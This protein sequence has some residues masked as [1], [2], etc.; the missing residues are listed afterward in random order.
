MKKLQL[1]VALFLVAGTANIF[2]GKTVRNTVQQPTAR[3]Q[4][5]KTVTVAAVS[6]IKEN[7]PVN[8]KSEQAAAA[9]SFFAGRPAR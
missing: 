6:N 3:K 7:R 1:F 5:A 2:A 9:N 4:F 8:T